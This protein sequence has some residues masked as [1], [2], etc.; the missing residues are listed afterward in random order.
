MAYIGMW[1]KT[2]G[3]FGGVTA[4]RTVSYVVMPGTML[5]S[6]EPMYSALG[7]RLDKVTYEEL[8]DE[9][10]LFKEDVSGAGIPDP[11]WNECL[12]LHD[13]IKASFEEFFHLASDDWPMLKINGE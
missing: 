4:K 8:K 5:T 7:A 3:D 10:V 6:E 11:V 12:N 2:D 1:Y 13:K 9:S